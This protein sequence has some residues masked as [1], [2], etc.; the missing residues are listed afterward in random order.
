MMS[1]SSSGSPSGRTATTITGQDDDLPSGPP[2]P[3]DATAA[4]LLMFDDNLSLVEWIAY[5]YHTMRLRHVVL[6]TDPRSTESPVPILERW[7]TQGL[8]YEYWDDEAR[9]FPSTAILQGLRE[10]GD[11][12]QL[13][14]H[15][16]SYFYARCMRELKE[17]RQ[18]SSAADDDDSSS[19]QW[20]LLTD[21]D[22][23]VAL[24]PHATEPSH[25]LY[26]PRLRGNVTYAPAD[27]IWDFLRD[28]ERLPACL[29]MAR[30]DMVSRE[31]TRDDVNAAVPSSLN[32]TAFYT[33][34][35]R[36]QSARRITGKCLVNLRAVRREE[37]PLQSP[38]Q[39]H[40]PL[41]RHCPS[42]GP[43][44]FYT[45]D[46]T[47]LIVHHYLGTQTQYQYRDDPRRDRTTG[48]F[49]EKQRYPTRVQD[50]LRS[51]LPGFVAQVGED[52]AQRLLQGAGTLGGGA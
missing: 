2:F 50:T 32:A 43:K 34:R 40:V 38:R 26:R 27:A 11:L 51:W 25:R 46:N 45:T 24:N 13:H 10:A 1:S 16:Q 5:H 21:V 19:D 22:E 42:W 30:R 44:Y 9:V 29:H 6:L 8:T 49:A 39:G 47:V 4:C 12:V 33:T 36:H 28:E 17:R 3:K 41:P 23:Y 35:W 15:R 37:I 18:S 52:E 7:K 31:S 48:G 20:L 14:R